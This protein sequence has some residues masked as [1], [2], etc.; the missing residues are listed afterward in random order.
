[1]L[2]LIHF[3]L[4]TTEQDFYDYSI[5]FEKDTELEDDLAKFNKIPNRESQQRGIIHR[6]LKLNNILIKSLSDHHVSVR[7]IDWAF[8]KRTYTNLNLSKIYCGTVQYQAPEIEEKQN[9]SCKVDIWAYGAAV[10]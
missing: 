10:Y 9:Y 3:D 6:D 8:S 1:M 4:I 7:V 2:N 5:R